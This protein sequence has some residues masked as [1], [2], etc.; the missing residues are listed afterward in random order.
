MQTVADFVVPGRPPDLEAIKCSTSSLTLSQS[1]ISTPTCTATVAVDLFAA[2]GVTCNE[3]EIPQ[4][5]LGA[6][7]ALSSVTA[8]VFSTTTSS[9]ASDLNVNASPFMPI[10]S[11]VSRQSVIALDMGS[12]WS[13]VQRINAGEMETDCVTTVTTWDMGVPLKRIYSGEN[14]PRIELDPMLPLL[15]FMENPTLIDGPTP[16]LSQF[17]KQGI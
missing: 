10:R 15:T 3:K 1:Q 4:T 9:I 7:S 17:C 8:T 11:S 2:R 14:Q 16:A 5:V 13:E 6:G 12:D